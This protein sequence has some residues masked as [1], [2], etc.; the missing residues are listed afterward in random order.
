MAGTNREIEWNISLKNWVWRMSSE[1]ED[2]FILVMTLAKKVEVG[3]EF[4]G[5]HSVLK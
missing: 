3:Y 2:D 4:S 1:Q 5:L